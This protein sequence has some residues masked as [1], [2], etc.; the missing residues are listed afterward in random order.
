MRDE[1]ERLPDAARAGAGPSSRGAGPGPSATA[2]GALH[3]RRLEALATLT[4]ALVHKLGNALGGVIGLVDLVERRGGAPSSLALL[5]SARE[6]AEVATTLVRLLAKLA[7]GPRG[8]SAP[9]DLGQLAA[10]AAELVEP[11]VHT[12]GAVLGVAAPAGSALARLDEA[13]ALSWFA[14]AAVEVMGPESTA[15]SP[16]PRRVR[17]G[18]RVKGERLQLVCLVAFAEPAPAPR[19]EPLAALGGDA[20][21]SWRPR[22]RR[23]ALEIR[24]EAQVAAVPAADAGRGALLV[25]ER[26]DVLAELV[27]L[28]LGEAGYTVERLADVSSLT[29]RLGGGDARLALVGS[30]QMAPAEWAQLAQAALG[31]TP[32][33]L[34]GEGPTGG[35]LPTLPKPF[36]PAELLSFVRERA[37]GAG[38]D[39]R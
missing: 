13:E 16:R 36:R 24:G 11:L 28:V 30:T 9:E 17:L 2:P 3:P 7:R 15:G 33:A 23:L 12:R 27:A 4:P 31:P 25:L 5:G 26:D 38:S 18:V 6:Q 19:P 22:A 1:G 29:R 34:L 10:R 20:R 35:P 21:V 32:L 39:G 8:T 14:T 37:G